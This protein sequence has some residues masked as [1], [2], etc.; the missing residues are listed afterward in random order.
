MNRNF[1]GRLMLCILLIVFMYVA[2][3][4]SVGNDKKSKKDYSPV[5]DYERAEDGKKSAFAD[6][7][8]AFIKAV[9]EK[10]IEDQ[11]LGEDDR[12]C[13]TVEELIGDYVYA[14]NDSYE[15]VIIKDN[16]GKWKIY[17]TNGD[18]SINGKKS[19][20]SKTD[21]LNGSKLSQTSCEKN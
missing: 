11:V 5:D 4:C 18:Y 13:Y 2:S 21:V 8:L 6:E 20:I 16:D 19:P 12:S 1:I 17:I 3:A 7:A 9:Q 10:N 14:T 15:G